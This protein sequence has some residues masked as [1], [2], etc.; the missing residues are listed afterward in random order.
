MT[1]SR[2]LRRMSGDVT[3]LYDDARLKYERAERLRH[4]VAPYAVRYWRDV[5][6]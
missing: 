2:H 3:A 5:D 1:A 4:F 6:D